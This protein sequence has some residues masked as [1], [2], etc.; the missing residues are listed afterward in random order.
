MTLVYHGTNVDSGILIARSGAI[1]CP[2]EINIEM[3]KRF[4]LKN[5]K[6]TFKQDYPGENLEQFVLKV[7]STSYA[8]RELE[9]RVK[10]VSVSTDLFCAE[11]YAI[12]CEKS[13]SE[14]IV[15]GI[16]VD[17]NFLNS[18]NPPGN[19]Q[20]KYISRKLSLDNLKEIHLSPMAEKKHG[21]QIRREFYNYNPFYF[22][23][24]QAP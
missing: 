20:V 9:S 21:K 10:S 24:E 18:I 11:G 8:E 4:Y 19:C 6:R 2:W 5:P 12:T 14:G 17:D 1:L 23:F 22:I 13:G 3:F 15:L 16:E 7:A